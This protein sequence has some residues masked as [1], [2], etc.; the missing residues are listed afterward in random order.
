MDYALLLFI[1]LLIIVVVMFVA[2]RT[3]GLD[4]LELLRAAE[5]K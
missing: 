5:G 4:P 3:V 2:A 1:V